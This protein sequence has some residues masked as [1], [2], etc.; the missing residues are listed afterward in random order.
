MTHFLLHYADTHLTAEARW[1]LLQW[2]RRLGL[3]EGFKGT[4]QALYKTLGMTYAQGRRA[5]KSIRLAG[6]IEGEP[7]SASPRRGRP[8]KRYAL[9]CGFREQW[10]A[11]ERHRMSVNSGE[12]GEEGVNLSLIHI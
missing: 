1:L 4:L 12:P 2:E 3:D 7:V 9:A 6:V 5:W 10:R 11:A 8:L